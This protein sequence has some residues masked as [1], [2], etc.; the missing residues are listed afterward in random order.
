MEEWITIGW[1]GLFLASFLA[2]T[3]LPF[4]S[5]VILGGM[6]VGGYDPF[7]CFLLASSGNW[8]GGLTS[9]WLGYLGKWQWLEKWF[10]VTKQQ[11]EKWKKRFNKWGAY[12]A[13][14]CWLPIIGDIL[15]IVLGFGKVNF[16]KAALLM[17]VG[18]S[19]RYLVIIQLLTSS[20]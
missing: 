7:M 1:L 10:S 3:I 11:V 15:A 4:S 14:L 16:L 5:E 6:I 19:I 8:L 17:L 9:Y 13:L 20:M 12:L 18:K 2:A